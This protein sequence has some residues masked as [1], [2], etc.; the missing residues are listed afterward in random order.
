MAFI[1]NLLM[2]VLEGFLLGGEI[3]ED[4][5]KI[6]IEINWND[7]I[8]DGIQRFLNFTADKNENKIYIKLPEYVEVIF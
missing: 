7:P 6:E 2:Q 3:E 8:G 1:G 4:W 5:N